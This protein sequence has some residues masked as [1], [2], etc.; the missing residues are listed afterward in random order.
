MRAGFNV[1]ILTKD[2]HPSDEFSKSLRNS[3]SAIQTD[4]KIEILTVSS[5]KDDTFS[6]K[7][8]SL[9]KGKRLT[10]SLNCVNVEESGDAVFPPQSNDFVEV[11]QAVLPILLQNT[12]AADLVISCPGSGSAFGQALRAET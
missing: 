5:E 6:L 12:P 7:L 8:S 4:R 10:L 11:Q 2:I 3:F 1:V 9:L